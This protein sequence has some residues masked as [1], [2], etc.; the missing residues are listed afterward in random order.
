MT[1]HEPRVPELAQ[2]EMLAQ[3]DELVARLTA[4]A[5]E[6]SSWEPMDRC[7][8]LIRRLLGRVEGLRIRLDWR[9]WRLLQKRPIGSH[10]L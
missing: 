2:L 10:V 7:R 9:G 8:A 1:K 4:W 3:V 5:D 6:E